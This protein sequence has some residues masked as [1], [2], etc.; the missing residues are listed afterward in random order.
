MRAP[1]LILALGA[2]TGAA[3]DD[4]DVEDTDD[5]EVAETD[6]TDGSGDGLAREDVITIAE[7]TPGDT[8][9][10]DPTGAWGTWE[11]DPTC[12]FTVDLT[13]DLED[14]ESGDGV[15]GVTVEFFWDD[16]PDDS[17]DATATSGEGGAVVG[18]QGPTCTTWSSRALALADETKTT[19]QMHWSE[20]AAATLDSFFNSVSLS[21]F[22]LI[23]AIVS[24][25]PDPTKGALAGTVYDCG[26]EGAVMAG[27]QV[28]VRQGT[29]YP[30]SQAIRYFV[31][32][33]PSVSQPATSED[34]LW[35]VA[36]VP[37]GPAVVEAWA[38]LAD[39]EEPTLIAQTEVVVEADAFVIADVY[40]SSGD[41]RVLPA[42]CLVPCDR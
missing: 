32:E 21:S 36:N 5:T 15:Q 25:E 9:C 28:I 26:G 12:V 2:C 20:P 31:N 6:D 38:V 17:P 10:L 14:F 41:G 24:V 16:V 4:D 11:A 39:G 3:A 37:V 33:F 1:L 8:T 7:P 40:T 27:V 35:L 29:T 13:G 19:V 30:S 42:S 22:G 23:S 34:G 18:V